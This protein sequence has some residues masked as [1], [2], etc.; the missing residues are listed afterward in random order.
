MSTF[1]VFLI[2]GYIGYRAARMG[3][4]SLHL[5]RPRTRA[6]AS[7]DA[8]ESLVEAELR[9]VLTW[10]CG[11]DFYLHH[12][13]VLLH[14]APGTAFPTAEIDHLAITPFGLFVFETKNWIGHIEPGVNAETLVRI[15]PSGARETRRSPLKQNRAK[16]AFLR[17]VMPGMWPVEGFGVFASDQ[18]SLSASLPVT[19]IGRKDLAYA[20]RICKAEYEAQGHKPVNVSAAWHAVLAVADID[21][22]TIDA[23][24][25]RVRSNEIG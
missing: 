18:S 25:A 13:P 6:E 17:S 3:R 14:H 10:L 24:R 20:M 12:G 16:V 11:D 19:L 1:V 8:G 5:R 21:A 4:G 22:G 9:R 2:L 15:A 23:H 7:G